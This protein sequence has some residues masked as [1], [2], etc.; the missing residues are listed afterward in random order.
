MPYSILLA[1]SLSAFVLSAQ[2]E[3][4]FELLCRNQAKE[5]AAETYKNCVTEHRQG[6]VEQIRK[7]YQQKLSELKSHYDGE[8]KKISGGKTRS[9]ESKVRAS[10]DDNIKNETKSVLKRSS[11]A[12][13]LP[14]KKVSSNTVK[15]EVIDFTSPTKKETLPN[16]E[17]T[18][19]VEIPVE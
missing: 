6:Q 19:I 3:S 8:L 12:R 15:S 11:G 17:N 14:E 18:E 2:A 5:I 10:S 1:L 7:E 9:S 13:E 4:S 16:D